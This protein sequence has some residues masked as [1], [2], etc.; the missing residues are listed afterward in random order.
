[1][2][3][4]TRLSDLRARRERAYAT[5][6]RVERELA[7]TNDHIRLLE[8]RMNLGQGH[9]LEPDPE[10]TP[11]DW[12]QRSAHCRLCTAPAASIAGTK[13]CLGDQHT[14][15]A[16]ID[17]G[18]TPTALRQYG[19]DAWLCGQPGQFRRGYRLWVCD[20]GHRTDQRHGDCLPMCA[21]R[22]LVVNA[23]RTW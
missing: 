15:Q 6:E 22:F 4:A 17:Q 12:A 10:A 11:W 8:A 13:P 9:I 16:E 5:L 14:C 7:L 23:G 18:A 3:Q 20:V 19:R 21:C 1:M 2:S